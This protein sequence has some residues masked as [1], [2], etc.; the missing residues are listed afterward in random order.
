MLEHC[1]KTRSFL[2][3]YGPIMALVLSV[4]LFWVFAFAS[5]LVKHT[6]A[7]W[8]INRNYQ[9]EVKKIRDSWEQKDRE[10]NEIH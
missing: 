1:M 7:M 8:V 9:R 2:C 3:D 4:I 6:L 10:E 5:L